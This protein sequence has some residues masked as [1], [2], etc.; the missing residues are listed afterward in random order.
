MFVVRIC[1]AVVIFFLRVK[2]LSAR[3]RVDGGVWLVSSGGVAP[4]ILPDTIEDNK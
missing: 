2:Q 4:S 1:S 3:V